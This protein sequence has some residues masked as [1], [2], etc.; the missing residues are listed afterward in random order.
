MVE[1]W[2][3]KELSACEVSI[4]LGISTSTFYRRA[5]EIENYDVEEMKKDNII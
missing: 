3:N 4:E 1:R 5:K 2:K